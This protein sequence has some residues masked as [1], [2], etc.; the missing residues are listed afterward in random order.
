MSENVTS[1]AVEEADEEVQA[2]IR[3]KILHTLKV[4]PVISPTMLQSG[5]L[6]PSVRPSVWRPVLQELIAE[7]KVVQDTIPSSTPSG[8][9]NAYQRLYLPET[10]EKGM[11]SDGEG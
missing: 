10:S 7:G 4:Y 9:Y 1:A 6:G 3:A 8:R 2:Q 11:L 5:G